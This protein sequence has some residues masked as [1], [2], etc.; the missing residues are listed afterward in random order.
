MPARQ[1]SLVA[2]IQILPLALHNRL[3]QN[4]C[5][6]EALELAA[7][8]SEA[9]GTREAIRLRIYPQASAI[10]SKIAKSKDRPFF[11]RVGRST[12][13]VAVDEAKIDVSI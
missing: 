1:Q 13:D 4:E 5:V 6:K 2:A 3:S 11:Q 10:C 12:S 8:H 7:G 9:S